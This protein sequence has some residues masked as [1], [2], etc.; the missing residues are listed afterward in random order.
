MD[1]KNQS[2][3]LDDTTYQI[4]DDMRF[5]TENIHSYM[6]GSLPKT[7]LNAFLLQAH[8]IQNHLSSLPTALPPLQTL[9][10]DAIVSELIRL[11]ATIYTNAILTH[12][13]LSLAA[14]VSTL[15]T[16]ATG[17]DLVPPA[18]WRELQGIWIWI[19]CVVNPGLRNRPEGLRMRI[20]LHNC[21]CSFGMLDAQFG[22]NCVEG[23]LS[24]QRWVRMRGERVGAEEGDDLS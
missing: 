24:V 19:L 9:P 10:V 3:G 4:L 15:E 14:P 1:D 5:L 21:I 11:T 20:L 7:S 2:W 6:S 18:R 16:I 12:I 13:T 22:L 17:I 8:H 23:F